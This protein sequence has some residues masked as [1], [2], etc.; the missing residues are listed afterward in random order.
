M[1]KIYKNLENKKDK[2]FFINN[3]SIHTSK[4]SRELYKKNKMDIIFYAQYH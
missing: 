3:A 4:L 2:T 1:D